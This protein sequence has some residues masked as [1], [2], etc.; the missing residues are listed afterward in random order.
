MLGLVKTKQTTAN[1]T[2]ETTQDK[3]DAVDNQEDDDQEEED[4]EV[5]ENSEKDGREIAEQVHVMD[6]D[7]M[8]GNKEIG[9]GDPN[10]NT[11]SQSSSTTSKALGS[12]QALPRQLSLSPASSHTDLSLSPIAPPPSESS[13]S[14]SSTPSPIPKK[15]SSKKLSSGPAVSASTRASSRNLVK[16]LGREDDNPKYWSFDATNHLR[17]ALAGFEVDKLVYWLKELDFAL[18]FPKG[19]VSTFSANIQKYAQSLSE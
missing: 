4:D 13:S 6:V 17:K 7:A 10:G 19:N 3:A 12:D 9:S 2:Y 18:G 11:A 8:S 14:E 15:S 5:E 1:E 16:A